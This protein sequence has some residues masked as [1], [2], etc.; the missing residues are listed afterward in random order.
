M[1]TTKHVP[2]FNVRVYGILEHKEHLLLSDELHNGR[3]ITKFPGGGLQFGEGT[4]DC[5]KREFREELNLEV[6]VLE[7]YYTTDFF[8]PSAFDKSQ[9]VI[10]IYYKIHSAASATISVVQNQFDFDP[11]KNIFQRFRWVS[12]KELRPADVSFPIDQKVVSMLVA[13]FKD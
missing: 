1:T 10:S 4:L 11:G 7:H 2:L 6:N 5:L 8:Q 12:L 9:Q 13:E 3:S